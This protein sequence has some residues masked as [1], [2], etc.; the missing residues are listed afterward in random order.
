MTSPMIIDLSEWQQ[1][2]QINY[3]LLAQ[4]IDHAIV[5]VQYGSAYCD[6][7][8]QTHLQRLQELGVPTAV[9]AWVRGVNHEDMAQEARVFYERAKKFQP[10]F[11]WLDVEE[12]TMAD[13]RGGVKV[14][15]QTLKALTQQKVGV[16][17]AHHLYQQFNLAVENFDALWLPSYGTNNGHFQGV[18]PTVNKNFDLH[19]YTSN[20]HLPGYSGPLDLNR[21]SGRKKLDYFTGKTLVTNT[22]GIAEKGTFILQAA[23]HLRTAPSSNAKSLAILQPGQAVNYD[24]FSHEQGHVWIRQRRSDGT[25]GY[26]ATGTSNGTQRTSAAWG[27]FK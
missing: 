4:H 9:Y 3:P 6:K 20:G 19:Q 1:P 8:Y 22:W 23:I 21:L 26:L 13:M 24:A 15:R 7:F 5:R 14:F 17:V 2:Q 25:Y 16:Y 12:Q 10:C 27:Q 11:Y 18:Q